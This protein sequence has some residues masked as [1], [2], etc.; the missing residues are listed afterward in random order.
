VVGKIVP[1]M[2]RCS[3]SNSERP[4]L[5]V[6]YNLSYRKN[7][8]IDSEVVGTGTSSLTLKLRNPDSPPSAGVSR[9]HDGSIGNRR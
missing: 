5:S 4:G 8:D 6:S 2:A 9:S 3:K 7:H 1:A